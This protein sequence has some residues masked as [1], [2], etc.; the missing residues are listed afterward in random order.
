MAI[1][2][3]IFVEAFG[4]LKLNFESRFLDFDSIA[5]D[6]NLPEYIYHRY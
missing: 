1:T 6:K 2:E 4:A 3:V 5:N